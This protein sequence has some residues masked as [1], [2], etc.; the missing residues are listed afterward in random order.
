MLLRPGPNK[1][2]VK[3]ACTIALAG[4]LLQALPTAAQDLEPRQYSDLPIGLNFLGVGYVVSTGGVLFDPAV[5]L[6]NASVRVDGS[7]LGYARTLKLGSHSAKLD[8]GLADVCLDG[9]ADYQGGRISRKVC[10]PSDAKMRLTVNFIGAPPRS[11]AEFGGRTSEL[12]VGAS[13]QLAVPTGQYDS[14]RLVNIGTNRW[15]AKLELGMSKVFP[16]W[17]VEASVAG[18]FYQAND[19]FFG[20][21]TKKQDPIAALQG[22][23]VRS[24]DKGIWFA[25]DATYY[26]GGRSVTDGVA[27][28]DLQSN[29]R[30]GATLSLP[31]N[32]R[33]SV[34]I[35]ASSGVS[36]RTGTDFDSLAAIWQYR[37]GRDL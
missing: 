32:K 8:A 28:P 23:I 5:A 30:I 1:T 4:G 27:N 10:G 7:T 36:T 6:E 14:S 2:L 3:L 13:L 17:T 18:T 35:G 20:G 33:Q 15:S 12:V 25:L 34:K 9:S 22:H 16:K 26:R 11:V 29:T 21:V 24:F 37:W 31:I 19:Q